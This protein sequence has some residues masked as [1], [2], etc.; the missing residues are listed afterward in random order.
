MN[1]EY[2]LRVND[3]DIHYTNE[4]NGGGDRFMTE[5]VKVVKEWYGK[6]D[7]LL[8][9]CAGPG[10][11]GYGMLGAGICNTVAFNEIFEPAVEMCKRTASKNK[12]D[13]NIY[14]K[15]NLDNV[16]QQFDL[17]VGNPPHWC[18]EEYAVQALQSLSSGHPLDQRL[19]QV[20]I[21]EDWNVHKSFFSNMKRLLKHNGK[22]LLQENATGSSPEQMSQLLQGT[23]LKIYSHADSVAYKSLNIYYLEVGHD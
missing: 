22:I 17:V 12:I 4:T 19:K 10:F 6:V 13:V 20:L 14:T 21:D 5:Y 8:E 7:N 18:K 23:G 1:I 16:Q 11:I 3:L 9:W 15:Q 2:I